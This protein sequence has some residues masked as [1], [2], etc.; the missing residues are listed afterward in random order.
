MKMLQVTLHT[1]NMEESVRF[2]S[3]VVGLKVQKTIAD[4]IVFMADSRDDTLIEL[5]SSDDVDYVNGDIS[6]GFKCSDPV[7]IR[8]KLIN[9]GYEPT[10]IISPEES[11]EFF[12]LKDPNGLRIQFH[13]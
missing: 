4:Q 11:V 8:A 6:V 1:D 5:I 10:D 13:N 3:E 9:N 2:Y 7:K 12:F